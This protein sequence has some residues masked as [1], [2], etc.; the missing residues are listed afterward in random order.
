MPLSAQINL[1]NVDIV[2]AFGFLSLSSSFIVDSPRE[3]IFRRLIDAVNIHAS[4]GRA[5]HRRAM[6]PASM[7][8]LR[9]L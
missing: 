3:A 9:E 6:P 1:N 7:L 2:V 8:T 4:P 5:V